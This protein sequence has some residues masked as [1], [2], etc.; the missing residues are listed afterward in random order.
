M[1]SDYERLWALLVERGYLGSDGVSRWGVAPV[2]VLQ[3]AEP[4]R[5]MDAN[6]AQ[7]DIVVCAHAVAA[8][9]PDRCAG[10]VRQVVEAAGFGRS[11]GDANVLYDTCCPHTSTAELLVGMIVAV[12]RHPFGAGGMDFGHVGIYVGDDQVMDCQD[13][14]V[15]TVPLDL[16]LLTY[17][18]MARPRWGWMGA[19]SLA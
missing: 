14:R 6:T 1:P 12:P 10:W 9:P 7:R 13:G 18:L 4:Q 19:V 11:F 15:R 8:L 16:W 2:R 17:G 5:L 3:G